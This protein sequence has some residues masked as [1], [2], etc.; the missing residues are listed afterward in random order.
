[1]N[2]QHCETDCPGTQALFQKA[3][4]N[5][6]WC[7]ISNT[8]FSTF[9]DGAWVPWLTHEFSIPPSA[10]QHAAVAMDACTVSFFNKYLRNQDD[11]LLD[12]LLTVYPTIFN[13]QSK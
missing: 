1:M 11:H 3:T 13:F 9:R 6:Y 5:A 7:Q 4:S 10:S 12:H 8:V 2:S